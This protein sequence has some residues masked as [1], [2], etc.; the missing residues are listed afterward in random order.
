VSNFLPC[1][2]LCSCA[3]RRKSP[4]DTPLTLFSFRHDGSDGDYF[5]KFTSN[6]DVPLLG[7][8]D[9]NMNLQTGRTLPGH[10]AAMGCRATWKMALTV[11]DKSAVVVVPI[12]SIAPSGCVNEAGGGCAA[13]A[14]SEHAH[15][16]L[17]TIHTMKDVRATRPSAVRLLAAAVPLLV[18]HVE[19]LP[20][21]TTVGCAG[22]T[23][24]NPRHARSTMPW[25]R[26]PAWGPTPS[27][28]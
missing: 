5:V 22:T 11:E 15:S 24:N 19:W 23:L 2:M 4:V 25:R 13:A 10:E 28:R 16:A 8:V 20:S 6:C 17:P 3:F 21:L 18:S 27:S 14:S 9:G 26:A 12:I 7:D 1:A